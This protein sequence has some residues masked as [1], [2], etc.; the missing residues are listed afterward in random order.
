M[1]FGTTLDNNAIVLNSKKATGS[2]GNIVV[3]YWQERKEFVTWYVD[4]DMNSTIGHYF[5]DNNLDG[6]IKD[7]NERS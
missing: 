1:E 3:A 6:A 5:G 2:E 4:K 7:F